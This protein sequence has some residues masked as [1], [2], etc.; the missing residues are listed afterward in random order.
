MPVLERPDFCPYSP[1]SA[2]ATNSLLISPEKLLERGFLEPGDLE[3]YPRLP[4]EAVDFP[5]VLIAKSKLL[6]QAFERFRTKAD[7]AEKEAFRRFCE[8]RTWLP[9]YATYVTRSSLNGKV[10]SG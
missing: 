5:K 8:S 3:Q 6:R 9:G 2:F 7:E 4:T 1:I 10:Y